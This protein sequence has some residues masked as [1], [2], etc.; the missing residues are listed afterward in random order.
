MRSYPVEENP[1]SSAVI[2][3]LWYKQT[4]TNTS[5]NILLLYYRQTFGYCRLQFSNGLIL[6][7]IFCRILA[8]EFMTPGFVHPQPK[9]KLNFQR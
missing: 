9:K 2:K 4:Q 6:I 7:L 8:W 3:I 5:T 1:N